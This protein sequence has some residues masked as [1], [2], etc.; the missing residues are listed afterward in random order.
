ME[1][2]PHLAIVTNVEDD[3]LEHYGNLRTLRSAFAEFLT[4]VENPEN[5]IVCADCADLYALARRE[6][7]ERFITYGFSD[8]SDVRGVEIRLDREGSSCR[9]LDRGEPVGYL[10][11][12]VP[13]RH[14]L[15][16]ALSVYTAGIVLG[17]PTEKVAYGLSEYRG[18]RR[19]FEILGTWKGATLI[20]DYAHH[21][22]E[23]RATLQA[24][25]QYTGGRC[26]AVFQPH[27]YSRTDQLFDE[28]AR[29]FIG[30]D[31]LVLSEIYP[32][33]E[34][35]RP[36]VSSK[37]LMARIEGVKESIY[38]PGLDDVESTLRSRLV[39]GDTVLFLGAGNVNQVAFRLL[40]ERA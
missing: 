24:L 9:V 34:K 37:H 10:R 16:N 5:R 19:R 23:I 13:G 35:P 27:R 33:G 32:A 28:F 6:L 20:D 31:L 8:W 30:V 18:T 4:S 36:G 15:A 2:D 12:R 3:H 22:T 21:P 26:I 39:E 25:Q 29:T 11:I 17:L 38:A 1:L 7:G 40:G 14:M